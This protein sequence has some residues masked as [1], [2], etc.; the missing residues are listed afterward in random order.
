MQK[1]WIKAGR[2]ANAKDLYESIPV[3]YPK[4]HII[5]GLPVPAIGRFP[6]KQA[7]EEDWPEI[8]EDNWYMMAL[9]IASTDVE[10]LSKVYYLCNKKLA[11]DPAVPIIY[12]AQH[13]RS[14]VQAQWPVRPTYYPP[15]PPPPCP[16]PSRQLVFS[17]DG[18]VAVQPDTVTQVRP[19]AEKVWEW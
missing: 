9:A 16:P 14:P 12:A 18:A 10:N 17:A 1:G 6:I 11:R 8:K 7:I 19:S 5:P 2:W 3:I 15:P 4:M 13:I